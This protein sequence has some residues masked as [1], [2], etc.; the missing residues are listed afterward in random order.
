[1]LR[2]TLSAAIISSSIVGNALPAYAGAEAEVHACVYF[3]NFDKNLRVTF[4][5]KARHCMYKQGRAKTLHVNSEGVHC[6]SLGHVE[7][8]SSSS[9]GDLCATADSVWDLSYTI[10]D[11]PYSGSTSSNW[12]HPI[13][14]HQHVKL[15]DADKSTNICSSDSLCN[16]KEQDWG[17]SEVGEV[18]IIFRPSITDN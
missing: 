7:G 12:W 10:S 1:M 8:K 15:I 18:Y 2:I 6:T 5:P 9:G 13:L 17:S 14:S 3:S 16:A 11:T 4:T